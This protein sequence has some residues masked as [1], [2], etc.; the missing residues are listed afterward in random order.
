MMKQEVKT[1]LRSRSYK[2]RPHQL[3]KIDV[4]SIGM[5]NIGR[6][7]L[8]VMACCGMLW[9]VV[10]LCDLAIVV[11]QHA[12]VRHHLQPNNQSSSKS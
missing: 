6:Q 10:S 5:A 11:A 7:T 1:E 12:L 8:V 2:T 3:V 9:H 4:E